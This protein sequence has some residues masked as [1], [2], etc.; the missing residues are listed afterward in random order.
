MLQLN[1]LRLGNYVKFTPDEGI[2][3]IS[4]IDAKNQT[5][6]GLNIKDI[7]PVPITEYWLLKMGF[8]QDE[9][10]AYRWY[11][12][13][14]FLS[15]ITYDLDDNTICFS[16]SWEF[17]KRLYVHEMQNLYFALTKEELINQ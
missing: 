5:A 8:R 9:D 16:D 1:E 11:K 13:W 17:G 3:I 14:E 10:L 15:I 6:N 7:Q 2:F 4:E 12:E